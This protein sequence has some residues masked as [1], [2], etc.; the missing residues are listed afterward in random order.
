MITVGFYKNW[1]LVFELDLICTLNSDLVLTGTLLEALSLQCRIEVSEYRFRN[2]HPFS[3]SH[4][5][6]SGMRNMKG[7]G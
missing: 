2:S 3:P 1:F 5:A 4:S 7:V 6:Y